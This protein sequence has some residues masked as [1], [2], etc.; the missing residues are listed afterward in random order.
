MHASLEQLIALR[1]G[2]PLTAEAGAHVRACAE[3]S[4]ELTRLTEWQR[5]LRALPAFSAPENGW[6]RVTERL[7][8]PAGE[9][10]AHW[11]P[12]A[13]IG[14]VA[15]LV[16]AVALVAWHLPLSVSPAATG[17]YNAAA[18]ASQLAQ[19]QA[20]SRYLESAVQSM[21]ADADPRIVNAGTA[22]T[23]AA[24]EDRIALVDYS[25]NH[26]A[27][28]PQ[29]SAQLTQ[30]WRQRVDLMQSLAAVRYTQVSDASWGQ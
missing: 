10:R 3:C 18:N 25:I 27:T 24:L 5:H 22:A 6:A 26:S 2:Q 11:L 30:L 13:V 19:L 17:T 28:Q 14:L 1:D 15:S 21:N 20:Q 29:A 4:H 23:V 16:A 7:E 12:A 9:R 8:K